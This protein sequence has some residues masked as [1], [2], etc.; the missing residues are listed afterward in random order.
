MLDSKLSVRDMG[1]LEDVPS[2]QSG[3]GSVQ[4][5]L[6]HQ[7]YLSSLSVKTNDAHSSGPQSVARA[8]DAGL[9]CHLD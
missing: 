5:E 4:K 9:Q 2:V 7:I 1:S 6:G 8:A 3:S